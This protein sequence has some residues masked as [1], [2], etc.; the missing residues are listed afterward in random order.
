MSNQWQRGNPLSAR[1][2]QNKTQQI[3][4]S[5]VRGLGTAAPSKNRRSSPNLVF[6]QDG[7]G[8]PAATQFFPRFYAFNDFRILWAQAYADG[9]NGISVD[10]ITDEE[11]PLMNV[12]RLSGDTEFD[13]VYVDPMKNNYVPKGKWVDL[14]TQGVTGGVENFSLFVVIEVL[15]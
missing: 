12:V 6:R 15:G 14:K 8:F 3:I 1:N 10:L 5:T 9:S 4:D 13:P 2:L 11:D 7:G